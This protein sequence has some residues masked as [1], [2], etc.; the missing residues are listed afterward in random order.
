M[1]WDDYE[2]IAEILIEKY[3][4]VNPLD[5]SLPKLFDMILKIEGFE[6]KPED[7]TEGKLERILEAW[8]NEY[9]LKTGKK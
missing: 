7:S 6:G 4:D 8:Y 9:Q 1:D 2:E 3:P 5:L